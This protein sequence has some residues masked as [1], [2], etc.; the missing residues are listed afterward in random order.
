MLLPRMTSWKLDPFFGRN[1]KIQTRTLPVD[2]YWDYVR[3]QF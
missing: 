2:E 3:A 1:M